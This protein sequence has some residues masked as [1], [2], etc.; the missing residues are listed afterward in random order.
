LL[1]LKGKQKKPAKSAGFRRFKLVGFNPCAP[2][3][4]RKRPDQPFCKPLQ[5]PSPLIFRET[6]NG[7]RVTSLVPGFY[8]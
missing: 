3:H 5:S 8:L 2:K 7:Q 6:R 4:H 1:C